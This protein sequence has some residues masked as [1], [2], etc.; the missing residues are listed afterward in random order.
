LF[1]DGRVPNQSITQSSTATSKDP[2]ADA[3]AADDPT[4]LQHS[5]QRRGGSIRQIDDGYGFHC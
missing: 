5:T 4:V 2:P 3:V 1:E